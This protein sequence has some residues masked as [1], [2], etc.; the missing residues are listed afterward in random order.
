MAYVPSTLRMHAHGPVRQPRRLTDLN[1]DVLTYISTYVAVDDMNAWRRTC[2]SI[3]AASDVFR[4]LELVLRSTAAIFDVSTFFAHEPR[5]APRVRHLTVME[6]CWDH[7]QDLNRACTCIAHLLENARS[8][9]ILVVLEA[10]EP[11][12]K[13]T[14]ISN[15]LAACTELETLTLIQFYGD[16]DGLSDATVELFKKLRAPLRSLTLCSLERSEFPVHVLD[17]L[18][19]VAWALEELDLAFVEIGPWDDDEP[20]PTFPLVHTLRLNTAVVNNSLLI[21][22]FPSLRTFKVEDLQYSGFETPPSYPD[23]APLPAEFWPRLE[24]FKGDIGSLWIAGAQVLKAVLL[25]VC[26]CLEQPND[27][28]ALVNVLRRVRPELLRICTQPEDSDGSMLF[29]LST[30]VQI[31]PDVLVLEVDVKFYV[32]HDLPTHNTRAAAFLVVR[33]RIFIDHRF[34]SS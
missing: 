16:Y 32:G 12:L 19:H 9:L 13:N 5:Y 1:D 18:R 22:A 24:V 14:S 10:A 11:W 33:V 4:F 3:A 28:L 29:D 2:K 27:V 15:A 30:L 34:S 25:N 23:N 26:Q 8:D 17:L 21:H 7:D 6:D 31:A 20:A